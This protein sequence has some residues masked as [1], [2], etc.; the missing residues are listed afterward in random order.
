MFSTFQFLPRGRGEGERA[1]FK[2]RVF[3]TRT[4][5]SRCHSGTVV[6]GWGREG[7]PPGNTKIITVVGTGVGGMVDNTITIT[8]TTTVVNK[9][10]TT[11]GTEG[12]VSITR[13]PTTIGADSRPFMARIAKRDG[14]FEVPTVVALRDK[15]VITSTSTECSAALSNKKLSAIITCD[16][17]DNTA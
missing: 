13:E 17:S 12:P 6:A 5:G 11:V 7:V 14:G 16:S 8:T 2:G 3:S 15:E 1:R 10:V 4:R 9:D